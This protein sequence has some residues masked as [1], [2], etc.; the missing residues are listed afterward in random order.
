MAQTQVRVVFCEDS[1]PFVP[2]FLG[3]RPA[4][5]DQPL[6]YIV[7]NALENGLFRIHVR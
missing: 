4:A 7:V 1:L 5:H 6:A 2:E 3:L